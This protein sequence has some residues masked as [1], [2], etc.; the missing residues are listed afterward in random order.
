MISHAQSSSPSCLMSPGGQF[1]RTVLGS[2]EVG[3]LI[4]LTMK[5]L[6]LGDGYLP[7]FL[8]S[9]PSPFKN[10]LV[11]AVGFIP[12]CGAP[13]SLDLNPLHPGGWMPRRRSHNDGLHVLVRKYVSKIGTRSPRRVLCFQAKGV[14]HTALQQRRSAF[15]LLRLSS[16][17]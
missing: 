8:R 10:I 4:L 5:C 7:S 12:T 14:S 16:G 9:V 15:S 3:P 17:F 6:G 2:T 1:N 11:R 13:V